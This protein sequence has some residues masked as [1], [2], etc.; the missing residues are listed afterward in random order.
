MAIDTIWS[1]PYTGPTINTTTSRLV[2]ALFPTGTINGVRVKL[3][4]DTANADVVFNLYLN[5]VAVFTTE[6]TVASG[7]DEIEVTGLS[8]ASTNDTWGV[9][10]IE[11]VFTSGAL[12]G[13][14]SIGF[15]VE[16]ATTSVQLTGTQTIGGAKTF[17]SDVLVPDEA[18][19]A[20]AWNGSLEVPT[21]NAV[22]DKIEALSLSGVSD[23]DKGDITVSGSGA[24]WT[25]DNSAITNAKVATGIDA[26]KIADGSVTN[27][28]F[29]YIGGLTSDAQ[30]QFAGKQATLV[31]GTNIKT[32]NGTTL[33]GSGDL[34]VSGGGG[35][36]TFNIDDG[37]STASGTFTFDDGAST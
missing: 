9:F 33:L 34:V 25:I 6:L 35:A 36:G 20:T 26:V 13:V 17:S 11:G 5:G 24:T 10:A 12:S 16:F 4:G 31:S 29:Q 37:S 27:T 19:D 7:T 8:V 32:I 22:R 28:E 23:G 18:Y 30:T 21:K 14:T 2:R 1:I 15:H 3:E